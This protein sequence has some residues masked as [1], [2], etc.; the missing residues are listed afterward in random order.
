MVGFMWC[1]RRFAFLH[2]NM[3]FEKLELELAAGLAAELADKLADTLADKLAA[4]FF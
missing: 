4:G 3:C 1:L 2:K